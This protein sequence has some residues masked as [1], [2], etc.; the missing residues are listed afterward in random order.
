MKS[1]RWLILLAVLALT[2]SALAVPRPR[3]GA[4]FSPHNGRGSFDAIPHAKAQPGLGS[5]TAFFASSNGGASWTS[6][7][8]VDGSDNTLGVIQPVV[9]GGQAG[10]TPTPIAATA[11]QPGQGAANFGTDA[12]AGSLNGD[13]F[14]P[15]GDPVMV[16]DGTKLH[17]FTLGV[18]SGDLNNVLQ[19]GAILHYISTDGGNSFQFCN[20]VVAHNSQE[21]SAGFEDKPWAA[22]D[23]ASGRM[24][25]SWTHFTADNTQSFIEV[26]F[27]NNAA[28]STVNDAAGFS[29]PTR[30][31]PGFGGVASTQGST[32]ALSGTNLVVQWSDV[33]QGAVNPNA[34]TT[35]SVLANVINDS[36]A[37]P[38]FPNPNNFSVV[39]PV[40]NGFGL[41]SADGQ[42]RIS[43]FPGGSTLNGIR[44]NLF[45]TSAADGAGNVYSTFNAADPNNNNVNADGT[46]SDGDI[47][48]VRST[49][50]G[51]SLSSTAAVQV[52]PPSTN[53]QFMPTVACDNATGSVHVV[54][55]DK[56]S[57]NNTN[58][59]A[60]LAFSTNAG[61]SFT[62]N[63]LVQ[64]TDPSSALQAGFD[65][66]LGDYIGL[67]VQDQGST[68]HAIAA[69]SQVVNR[70]G[71]ADPV[72][73]SYTLNGSTFSEQNPV[74][75]DLNGTQFDRIG[76][77]SEISLAA[78]SNG[79]VAAG[80]NDASDINNAALPSPSP[81]PIA[82]ISN[83]PAPTPTIVGVGGPAPFLGGG[84]GASS[85][86]GCFIATAAY[87]SY[88]DPHVN[89]LRRFRDQVLEPTAPGRAFVAWYYRWSPPAARFI[90]QRPL[91]R[92][93]VRVAL[94]PL[95][96]AVEQPMLC[97]ALLGL[98]GLFVWRRRR[99]CH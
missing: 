31:D 79:T 72:S 75:M 81:P 78:L 3:S 43:P 32:L 41:L 56:N 74:F 82:P 85:G 33:P 77:C 83:V 51:A 57:N 58:V 73:A 53:D 52:N 39:E 54:Y 10:P 76:T 65:P 30:I 86:G 40:I 90:A 64:A 8:S 71:I 98:V 68:S 16:S 62:A 60:T 48:I 14:V 22:F 1:L 91:L 96:A 34:P 69:F 23:P 28:A 35:G 18:L 89:S 84:G 97:L 36:G 63:A 66:A 49:V 94:T 25:V 50:V 12:A 24:F 44:L 9:V 42:E 20:F 92:G 45:P 17:F 99:L 87:G 15:L 47:F 59:A 37:S 2:L 61:A 88:L 21:S 38:V 19:R 46:F 5:L 7:G 55:Y 67:L 27:M 13:V 11:G 29:A 70:S 6:G 4:H 95:V 80:T 26:A 93:L